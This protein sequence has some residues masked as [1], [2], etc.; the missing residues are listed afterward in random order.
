MSKKHEVKEY[1]ENH[2]HE[3]CYISDMAREIIGTNSCTT[4]KIIKGALGHSRDLIE[5]EGRLV[6]PKIQPGTNSVDAYKIATEDDKDYI[7]AELKERG[8]KWGKLSHRTMNAINIVRKD[9]LLPNDEIPALV[10]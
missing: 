6:I 4:R 5:A 3:W 8:R 10:G 2:T 7:L 9:K 1:L